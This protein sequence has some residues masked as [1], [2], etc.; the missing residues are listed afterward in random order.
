MSTGTPFDAPPDTFDD[1][2]QWGKE[3]VPERSFDPDFDCL[4]NGDYDF[5]ILEAELTKASNDDR[6]LNLAL[7]PSNGPRVR[8][9]YWL[10]KQEAINSLGADLAI[11]GFDSDRWGKQG[12]PS[13]AQALPAAVARLSGI[14]FRGHKSSREGTGQYKG[15]VFHS[16]Q[17]VSRIDGRPMPPAAPPFNEFQKPAPAAA[18]A[19]GPT[20]NATPPW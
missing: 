4:A 14:K 10:N 9:T 6:V 8:Y 15:R 2:N 17:I 20:S 3:F 19:N 7:Q 5:Q 13:L 1:L 16:L 12:G 18:G 11:L